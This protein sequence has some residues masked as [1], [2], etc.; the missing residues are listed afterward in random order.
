MEEWLAVSSRRL[1]SHALYYKIPYLIPEFVHNLA[2]QLYRCQIVEE[3]R[4]QTGWFIIQLA[5]RECHYMWFDE[6]FFKYMKILSFCSTLYVKLYWHSCQRCGGISFLSTGWWTNLFNTGIRPQFGCP[7]VQM[8]TT[9]QFPI[10]T[11]V[12]SRINGPGYLQSLFGK[13]LK[14]L[15]QRNSGAFGLA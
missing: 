11:W 2:A 15:C 13:S 1:T 3:F 4:Y 12:K 5:K 7:T 14:G 6:L 9:C 8:P 10:S